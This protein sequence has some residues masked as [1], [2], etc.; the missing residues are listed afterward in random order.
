MEEVIVKRMDSYTIL[1]VSL[2][3]VTLDAVFVG[4]VFL[5]A[6]PLDSMEALTFLVQKK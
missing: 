5:T 3:L 1:N 2:D 6:K 4:Q